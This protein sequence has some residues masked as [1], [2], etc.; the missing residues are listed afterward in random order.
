M[1]KTLVRELKFFC[2]SDKELS[3]LQ[4]LYPAF[5]ITRGLRNL[6]LI[7]IGSGL[8]VLGIEFKEAF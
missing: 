3:Q 5:R 6:I 1:E 2:I 8:F 7:V 4:K